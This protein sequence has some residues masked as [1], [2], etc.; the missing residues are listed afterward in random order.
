MSASSVCHS[1]G[2]TDGIKFIPHLRLRL[3]QR[4]H[5]HPSLNLCRVSLD[6]QPLSTTSGPSF[7]RSANPSSRLGAMRWTLAAWL[8]ILLLLPC[9]L[10]GASSGSS[11]SSRLRLV[12][13]E[14]RVELREQVR[15]VGTALLD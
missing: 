9:H 12:T 13:D 2:A 10:A 4:L 15:E 5:S 14:R 7:R 11:S 6:L 1:A 8:A 3:H